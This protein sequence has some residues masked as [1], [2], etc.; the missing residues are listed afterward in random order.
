[1]PCFVPPFRA[2][3][4]PTLMAAML[5]LALGTAPAALAQM[6][7]QVRA[8]ALA[9][10]DLP[11]A[12][13]PAGRQFLSVGRLDL[14]GGAFCT[15]T[16]I[17]EDQAL[18]AAH[19]LVD[20]VSGDPLDNGR[21]EVRL[22]LRNG[23]SEAVRTVQ[24]V[25]MSGWARDPEAAPGSEEAMTRVPADLAILALDRPV[26]LPQVPPIPVVP[27]PLP[28]GQ[29]LTVVSYARERSEAAALQDDCIYIAARGDGALILDCEV[30][31][32]ASGAPVIRMQDGVAQVVA[33]ISAR[34]EMTRRDFPNATVALA[35]PLDGP[36][37]RGLLRAAARP[38]GPAAESGV[39]VRRPATGD[40]ARSD[41]ARFVRP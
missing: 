38:S 20:P 8:Q 26:R 4:P 28:E 30:D 14:G 16:L 15:V 5:A 34:A 18:T 2:I 10:R 25:M 3:A 9:A 7:G 27:G 1:M 40:S 22:G 36:A 19:C 21:M 12:L 35:A 33:V 24:R 17:A 29:T 23:R 13:M 39:R 6:P 31:Q 11:A 37:G 32:G 41:G